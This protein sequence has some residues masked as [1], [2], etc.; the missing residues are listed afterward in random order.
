MP[1]PKDPIL[2]QYEGRCPQCYMRQE[3]CICSAIP[4]INNQCY[5]TVLMHQ[6]ESYKT[7]NTARI[8][9]MALEQSQILLRG[10]KDQ[11]LD[12]SFLSALKSQP[13]YLTLH[14][15]A[16]DLTPEFLS[17]YKAPFHLVVPDGN[18][19][20]A[21][22]MGQREPELKKIPWVKLPVKPRPMARMRKEHHPEGMSTLEAIA[23]AYGI[24][25]SPDIEKQ[26]LELYDI[27]T[28]R[29]LSTRPWWRSQNLDK[30]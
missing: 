12:L 16:Q 18:W 2:R 11:P 8:A 1:T 24:I 5:L 9:C 4:K 14:E 20:Q 29:T 19:R 30:K 6:R 26:L 13:L 27:M 17:H 25:E 23:H 21:S 10:I 7:T 3:L 22:R 15:T 28:E